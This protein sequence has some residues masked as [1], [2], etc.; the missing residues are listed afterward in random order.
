MRTSAILQI[1]ICCLTLFQEAITCHDAAA[2]EK[3]SP[4]N[5]WKDFQR[6]HLQVERFVPDPKRGSNDSQPRERFNVAVYCTKDKMLVYEPSGD[7]PAPLALSV[8]HLWNDPET[9]WISKAMCVFQSGS[10]VVDWKMTQI[11]NVWF[12]E[13]P[14]DGMPFEMLF[15]H[16][17]NQVIE[18]P[19]TTKAKVQVKRTER[20]N[21]ILME[22]IIQIPGKDEVRISQTWAKGASW[23]REFTRYS[24]GRKTLSA[25]LDR[26]SFAETQGE[27]VKKQKNR[28]LSWD[29]R[30]Q[31]RVTIVRSS[32]RASEVI[33]IIQKETKLELVIDESLR[34]QDPEM[35]NLQLRNVPAWAVM[36]TVA[37]SAYKNSRWEAFPPNGFRLVP[38]SAPVVPVSG[39]LAPWHFVVTVF[40]VVALIASAV[41]AWRHF[42]IISK[43]SVE[44]K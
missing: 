43:K 10:S 12:F 40:M 24:N 28:H 15:P 6:W 18:H 16:M 38:V 25:K 33:S 3:L 42:K 22:A 8:C 7:V 29:Q 26:I 44:R 4:S 31:C 23:W 37:E 27:A 20:P 21:E 30:L 14:V 17:P 34:G 35:G 9:G 5:Q 41:F 13:E 2:Q 19:E 32:A 39:Q 36:R 1:A 11:G